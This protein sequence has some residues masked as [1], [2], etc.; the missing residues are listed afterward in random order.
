MSV[1]NR[2]RGR[3]IRFAAA[4]RPGGARYPAEPQALGSLPDADILDALC[5]LPGE[6]RLAVYLADVEG[7][8]YR[9]IAEIMGTPVGTVASRL[10]QARGRLRDRL[11]AAA[12]QR[13]LTPAPG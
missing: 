11:A 9:E 1:S 12:A 10:H 8:R 13:G 2:A 5:G 7:Y 3:G 6:L 4:G